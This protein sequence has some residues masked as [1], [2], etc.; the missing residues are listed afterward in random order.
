M[1]NANRQVAARIAELS[2]QYDNLS[3]AACKNTINQMRISKGLHIEL[4]PQVKLIDSGIVNVIKRQKQG[5]NYIR[6]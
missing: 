2:A 3:F 6:G 4:I 5:W 1:S